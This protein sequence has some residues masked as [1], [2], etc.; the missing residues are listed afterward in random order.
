MNNDNVS[1]A[2][3]LFDK[4]SEEMC[5]GFNFKSQLSKMTFEDRSKIWEL[6]NNCKAK[7]T[8]AA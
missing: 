5:Y 4:L 2:I 6:I 8:M 1:D 7:R 3:E